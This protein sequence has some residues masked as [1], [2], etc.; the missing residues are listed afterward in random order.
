MNLMQRLW[1]ASIR[2]R[3]FLRRRMP[4]NILLDKIRTRQG[5]KWGI[6]A[7]LLGGIYVFAAAMC[8][9]LI[10]HGW[11]GW[12]YLLFALLLWNGLKF[13]F[14]G[15]WSLILLLRV[16]RQEARA[17]KRNRATPTHVATA[18]AE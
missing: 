6:P 18:S 5:L 17:R 15:P 14:M 10:E 9:T 2:T 4:T 7:M 16:R 8:I 3:V 12:L 13:L 11:S 1:N